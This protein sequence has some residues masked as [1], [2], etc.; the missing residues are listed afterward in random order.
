MLPGL[1]NITKISQAFLFSLV[2]SVVTQK[3]TYVTF[4][5]HKLQPQQD[6]LSFDPVAA[7]APVL[8]SLL[9]TIICGPIMEKLGRKRAMGLLAL[10]FILG[11]LVI[12]TALNFTMIMVGRLLTGISFGSSRTL[13]PI[14][15]WRQSDH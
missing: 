8:S 11:W 7:S 9:G 15:V 13:A 14:Y 2:S 4:A 12:G 3:C 6:Y 5:S 1:V 10:P